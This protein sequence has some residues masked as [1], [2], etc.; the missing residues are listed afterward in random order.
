MKRLLLV[1]LLVVVLVL[2][3]AVPA[4][5]KSDGA[6]GKPVLN[7]TLKTTSGWSWS[8]NGMWS[9]RDL[10]EHAQV[11]QTGPDSFYFVGSW[12]GKWHTL[13]GIPSPGSGTPQGH[14]GSGTVQG[15]L[16]ATFSAPA[17][18]PNNWP[19]RG[20][21]GT[22]DN[23]GTLDDLGQLL[24]LFPPNQF[25]TVAT[26]F[27]GFSDFTIVDHSETCRYR[28]QTWVFSLVNGNSGDIIIP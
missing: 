15:R 10:V 13:S 17:V 12:E 22:F 26:F 19:V 6:R 14:D 25:S 20:F 16:T 7:I 1:G 2:A 4:L 23:G 9:L 21:I 18:N 8:P 27:P 28:G 24:P 11:W 5:G 3:M